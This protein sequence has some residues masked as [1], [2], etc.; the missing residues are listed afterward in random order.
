[1]E[2]IS[3]ELEQA[4]V[5]LVAHISRHA[6]LKRCRNGEVSLSALKCFLIQ[7]GYYSR[8]FTRYLCALMSNLRSNDQVLCL[9]ENLFEELGFSDEGLSP[10]SEVYKRMLARFGLD[11]DRGPPPLPAT[12]SLIEVMAE[13]CRDRNPARGLGA[14]CLG[15]EALVP[16]MYADILAGFEALGV[17]G[18][19]TEFFRM[20]VECDDGHAETMRA[21]MVLT[22]ENEPSQLAVMIAAGRSLVRARGDFF[23]AILSASCT[24]ELAVRTFD[25]GPS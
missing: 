7:H 13:H 11:L 20:H 8:H 10:H 2:P 21:I 16:S 9:A 5:E 18:T 1:M 3:L 6:F 15:A 24:D 22:A 17:K 23:S 19:E 14:L 25:R 4:R 12:L